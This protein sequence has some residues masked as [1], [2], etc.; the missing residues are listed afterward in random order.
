MKPKC[1]GRCTVFLRGHA[2]T[3]PEE[4]AGKMPNEGQD[5]SDPAADDKPYD[6]EYHADGTSKTMAR[7]KEDDPGRGS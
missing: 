2:I 4:F 5:E 7:E 6:R 3:Q 1:K